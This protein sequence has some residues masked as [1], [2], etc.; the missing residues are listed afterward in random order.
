[1]TVPRAA[2]TKEDATPFLP[3]RRTLATLRD[4]A[5]QCRG[6]TLYRNATQAVFGEGPER[7]RVVLVGEQPGDS[8]DL[9][10]RP[11]VGP[12]GRML[13]RALEAAG[14]DRSEVYLTN[15]VKHFSFERRG[16][17]RLHKKPRPGE[18]RAC[19]PWLTA[20]LEVLA[21]EA[22]VLLGA[23]AAQSVF[24]PAFRV[25]KERGKPLDSE[26]ARS[27]SPRSSRPQFYGR[28][29]PQLGSKDFE[30]SQPTFASWR[31]G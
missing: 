5:G 20:E 8:E 4:A 6:C 3:R 27:S 14:L 10:G 28:P 7:A 21:P 1:M 13:D 15:A 19:R 9:A 22:V 31:H 23:T 24:G 16:K 30:I 29:T 12:A 26:I 11:F 17:A 25:L 2:K 18:V